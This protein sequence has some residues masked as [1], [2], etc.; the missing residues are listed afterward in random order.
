[1]K[2]PYQSGETGWRQRNVFVN[3]SSFP[4]RKSDVRQGTADQGSTSIANQVVAEVQR[5]Q[6]LV[7]TAHYHP[8][9]SGGAKEIS[10]E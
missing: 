6:V 7:L 10:C 1:M 5:L 8:N 3:E 2:P 4:K 9:K